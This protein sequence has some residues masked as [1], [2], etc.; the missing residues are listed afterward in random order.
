MR[1]PLHENNPIS[2]IQRPLKQQHGRDNSQRIN[3]SFLL[4]DLNLARNH[5]NGMIPQKIGYLKQL[6]SL[7]LSENKL[8]GPIPQSLS[9]LN[10]L[11][12][13]N[14]SYNNLSGII[15]TGNQL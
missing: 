8:S 9:R 11:S 2:D 4:R 10:Y 1:A 15:P 13:L 3:E 12:H 5:L 6:E 14:L 7:D